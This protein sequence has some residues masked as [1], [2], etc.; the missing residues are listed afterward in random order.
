MPQ[1][2]RLHW[3]A[4]TTDS[5]SSVAAAMT[6][7]GTPFTKNELALANGATIVNGNITPALNGGRIIHFPFVT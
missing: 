7:A 5:W 1:L 4:T 6:A 3:K 2:D